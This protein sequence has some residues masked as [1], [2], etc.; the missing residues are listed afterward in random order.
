M[1]S[2]A[3]QP[4]S[5]SRWAV[6]IGIDDY[7]GGSNLQGCAN[8]AVLVSDYMKNGLKIPSERIFLHIAANKGWGRWGPV[9]PRPEATPAAVMASLDEVIKASKES[10]QA[11]FV[12]VHFSGHGDTQRTIFCGGPENEEKRQGLLW[13]RGLGLTETSPSAKGNDGFK[14]TTKPADANDEI[15]CFPKNQGITD[16]EFGRKMTE[17]ANN[18]LIVSVTIDC[19]FSGGATR[20]GPVTPNTPYTV[21]CKSPSNN[22]QY[23]GDQLPSNLDIEWEFRNGFSR[24]SLLYREQKHFNAM[25]ACQPHQCAA[26]GITERSDKKPFGYFTSA[27]INRLEGVDA[28]REYITYRQMQGIIGVV[29]QEKRDRQVPAH[30]GPDN[31]IIFESHT[32]NDSCELAYVKKGKADGVLSIVKG[33][34]TGAHVGDIYCLSERVLEGTTD[35]HESDNKNLRIKITRVDQF[36][37]DAKFCDASIDI[38]EHLKTKRVAQ[39]VKR[40]P[41]RVQVTSSNEPNAKATT[42]RILKESFTHFELFPSEEESESVNDP[43]PTTARGNVGHHDVETSP[44]HLGDILMSIVR[45]FF[46][47]VWTYVRELFGVNLPAVQDQSSRQAIL[48]REHRRDL[49]FRVHVGTQGLE[50]RD[51]TGRRF[52][53]LPEIPVTDTNLVKHL[54]LALETLYKFQLLSRM[55]TPSISNGKKLFDIQVIATDEYKTP[56]RKDGRVVAADC[57]KFKN[58]APYPL[59]VTV[60][61]LNPFYGIENI[62][63]GRDEKARYV[64]CNGGTLEEPIIT[65]VSPDQ[66]AQYEKDLIIYDTRKVIV[67]TQPVDF[68][69]FEQPDLQNFEQG[70]STRNGD[71]ESGNTRP[72]LAL[73]KMETTTGWWIEDYCIIPL[74]KRAKITKQPVRI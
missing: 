63:P 47:A 53:R 59:Y 7:G 41:I 27:L 31:R 44:S 69:Y 16:V 73:G 15:L 62:F 33:Q 6:I 71:N 40:A 72:G 8:D 66:V 18:G 4:T 52:D 42:K 10:N 17:M 54:T 68:G 19:C 46:L 45:F 38:N 55:K 2:P 22:A 30:F 29:V 13:F 60:L 23:Y 67:A 70:G 74:D 37:S 58:D 64:A 28:H 57:L 24:D 61:N 20:I 5:L 36:E 49:E 65:V 12:H 26:E 35:T 34:V 56:P 1:T 3:A 14:V 51:D 9:T 48:P 11:S 21:R 32:G 43:T 25:L 50:I 39:L